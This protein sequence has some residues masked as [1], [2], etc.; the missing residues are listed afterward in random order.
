MI[1]ILKEVEISADSIAPAKLYLW[2][3][4][5]GENKVVW[6]SKEKD[7]LIEFCDFNQEGDHWFFSDNLVGRLYGHVE[8]G[9]KL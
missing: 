5:H 2:S 7:A 9:V 3:L 8:L 1:G 6:L 4:P